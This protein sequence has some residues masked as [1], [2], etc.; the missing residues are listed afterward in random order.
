MPRQVQFRIQHHWRGIDSYTSTS[1]DIDRV[2]ANPIIGEFIIC[3][4]THKSPPW[5]QRAND[6]YAQWACVCNC[7][8]ELFALSFALQ[9]QQNS[10]LR[11]S[12]LE[13]KKIVFLLRLGKVRIDA[14][15]DVRSTSLL[16]KCKRVVH[17]FLLLLLL[18]L[19]LSLSLFWKNYE[20]VLIWTCLF[21]LDS[22][23]QSL[24]VKFHKQSKQNRTRSKRYRAC[25]Q[26]SQWLIFAIPSAAWALEEC[27]RRFKWCNFC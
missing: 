22:A 3:A 9:G 6:P 14:N 8:A 26:S 10:P 16:P 21:F 17:N 12:Y 27:N 11:L 23:C 7:R 4:Y 15:S 18:F 1:A 25:L 13:K 24:L 5:G 2:A 20:V 19:L